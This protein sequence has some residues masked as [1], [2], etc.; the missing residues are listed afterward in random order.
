MNHRIPCRVF[1]AICLAFTALLLSASA[2]AQKPKRDEIVK[3]MA[4]PRATAL[5]VTWLYVSPDKSAQKVSRVA[6]GREMV[7]A[8]KSGNW[9]R[10]YA[11]TDVREVHSDQDEPVIGSDDTTPPISGWMEARG[12][13][14]ETT[15][16]GDQ[17]LMG[18]AANQEAAASDPRGPA[19]AAQ[20]ARLLY[21]RIVEMFPNSP[22]A[23]EAAWRAADIQWQ[24]QK[25]DISTR[26]SAKER[27]PA[28][29]EQID[30][31]EMK[32]VIKYY[33]NTR[34]AD[35][36]AFALIDNKL[37]GDWGGQ[38]KCPAKESEIYEKFAS[39]HP[40]GPRTAQALYQA[41]Y[42][43]C[44]L[45]DMFHADRNDKKADEARNR[46]HDLAARLRDKFAQSDYTA[47]ATALVF[48]I[49]QGIPVYGIDQ[50]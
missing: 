33:P 11:N 22:L 12:I 26:P 9:L 8:E 36:A 25:A 40:D 50:E 28:L 21:R 42:R 3:P 45:V 6:T 37:C 38:E 18:E 17:I 27:D 20:S 35:M 5:R 19:N 13:V 31:T 15:P 4:G 2:L 30:D 10:V 23:A 1:L 29:R 7:V 41:V 14:E 32:R 16:N 24:I 48:K 49:D 43:Q 47:R 44:A 34:Q 46:A 39:E